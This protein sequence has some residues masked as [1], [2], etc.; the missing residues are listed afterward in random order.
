[1]IF[2]DVQGT[3]LKDSDKSLINGAKELIA[4]L[5]LKEIP[6]VIITNNT[7]D[8]N[9]LQNLRQKGLDLSLHICSFEFKA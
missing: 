6:Y 5:N 4:W 9:F 7:K 8:L 2:L 3:L 1:M